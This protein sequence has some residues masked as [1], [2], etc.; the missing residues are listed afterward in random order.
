MHT[1]FSVYVRFAKNVW[2]LKKNYTLVAS[3]ALFPVTIKHVW[4]CAH[5]NAWVCAHTNTQVYSYIIF[6]MYVCPCTIYRYIHILSVYPSTGYPF[7]SWNTVAYL[8]P[9]LAAHICCNYCTCM[10]LLL[11]HCHCAQRKATVLCRCKLQN[12]SGEWLMPR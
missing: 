8:V 11:S 12:A 2:N 6:Y 5:I 4:V 7:V 10:Y 1:C 9:H 3:S